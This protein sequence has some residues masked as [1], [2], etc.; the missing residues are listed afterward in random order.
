MVYFR[1]QGEVNFLVTQWGK[2]IE[3][4]QVS[5]D[6]LDQKETWLREVEALMECLQALNLKQGLILTLKREETL[7]QSQ[8]TILLRPL[9]KWLLD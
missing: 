7:T 9:Y 5:Y 8:K 1:G 3:A 2:P 6:D 4:I